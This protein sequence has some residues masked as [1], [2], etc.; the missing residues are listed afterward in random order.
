MTNESVANR[1]VADPLMCEPGGSGG[2]YFPL[3]EVEQTWPPW[4]RA[5]LYILALCYMFLGVSV[6]ADR[7]V[8]SI[9]KITSR[10]KQIQLKGTQRFMTVE[11]WNGTVANLTLMALGSS[12][13]EILLS[14]IEIMLGGFHS[15]ELGPSTIVGSAAFNLFMIIAVCIVAI[16]EGE[17]RQIRETGVF[18]VTAVFSIFAYVWL[19]LIV[20]VISP[21][22]IDIWEGAV[23]VAFFPI[24]V[25][26]S[27]LFDIGYFN[28]RPSSG[29]HKEEQTT[30]ELRPGVLSRPPRAISLGQ[31]SDA[32]RTLEEPQDPADLQD[33]IVFEDCSLDVLSGLADTEIHVGILRRGAAKGTVTCSYRTQGFTATPGYDYQETSGAITFGPGMKQA[34]IAVLLLPKRLGEHSDQFQI[35]LENLQG[36]AR[37]DPECDGSPERSLLMVTIHNANDGVAR[38]SLAMRTSR[39]VDGQVNLDSCR[40]AFSNWYDDLMEAVTMENESDDGDASPPGAMGWAM[41]LIAMPWKIL[42]ALL[43]PPPAFFGGWLCFVFSLVFI[44][45]TT[46]VIIDFAEL[47]GCVTGIEDSITAISLVALGTSMPDL[48]AS[49]TAAAQEEWA[50]ASI[51]NVTGSNSVNVFLGIGL[52][53]LLAAVYWAIAG[54]SPEWTKKYGNI[55]NGKAVFVVKGGDL[56][57]SVV[58][59]SL[60]AVLALFVIIFRRKKFG[61]ELGG[62]KGPRVLS[63]LL[64]GLLWLFY[65][66]LS[67]WKIVF[68]VDSA[69]FVL[70]AIFVGICAVE[71]LM[72]VLGIFIFTCTSW[73]KTDEAHERLVDPEKGSESKWGQPPLPPPADS[74]DSPGSGGVLAPL[75]AHWRMQPS[76]FNPRQHQRMNMEQHHWEEPS[77]DTASYYAG[78]SAY[79]GDGPSMYGASQNH[80]R[81]SRA[82][83]RAKAAMKRFSHV[84]LVCVAASRWRTAGRRAGRRQH[85]RAHGGQPLLRSD[86]FHSLNTDDVPMRSL[87]SRGDPPMLPLATAGATVVARGVVGAVAYVTSPWAEG[88]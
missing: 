87:D 27:Y 19:V 81:A 80:G 21:D 49:Q 64:F 36:D 88:A 52:P 2:M 65:L 15:G 33:M 20:Q 40:L 83:V 11:V 51:V 46:T 13:P 78:S 55:G 79:G 30:I 54:P 73:L 3:I 77:L 28:K 35:V 57:F 1:A 10:R 82:S 37:F 45:A 12:A 38:Q 47:F 61:G 86:S 53:W 68:K 18:Y 74:C 59:F 42:F 85:S 34:T 67:I 58:V 41:F 7:F 43:V 56:A 44:G 75:N 22:I 29:G 60:A 72:L 50:D 5:V 70:A 84:A 23:T 25:Y 9:E 8:M 6:V 14:L 63:A 17:T 4:L 39:F 66:G 32:H 69:G 76:T 26:A 71:N 31:V 16:P 24:L 48:F 62:P